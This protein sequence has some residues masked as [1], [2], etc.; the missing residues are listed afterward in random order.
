MTCQSMR[1]SRSE[2]KLRK[3]SELESLK[4][5]TRKTNKKSSCPKLR[6]RNLQEK[7]FLVYSGTRSED[8]CELFVHECVAKKSLLDLK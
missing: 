4:A 3:S 1:K 2:S 8:Y 5:N 6:A 7:A